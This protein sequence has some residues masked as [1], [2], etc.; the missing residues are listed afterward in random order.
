M[1]KFI[2]RHELAIIMLIILL[3]DLTVFCDMTVGY[4][5]NKPNYMLFLLS[6]FFILFD[7]HIFYTIASDEFEDNF[8]YND[9]NIHYTINNE[10]NESNKLGPIKNIIN[11]V[12]L[13]III[14][15]ICILFV[16]NRKSYNVQIKLPIFLVILL[17]V[18]YLFKT[19]L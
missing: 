8:H 18:Y 2:N 12:I 7:T 15:F 19:N 6:L 1:A 4:I 5:I 13:F 16:Y 3:F 9:S 11:P 14:I 10:I 17:L